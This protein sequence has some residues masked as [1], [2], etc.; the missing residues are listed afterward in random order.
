MATPDGPWTAA[1]HEDLRYN[2]VLNSD[3]AGIMEEFATPAGWLADRCIDCRTSADGACWKFRD[4]IALIAITGLGRASGFP[5]DRQGR[6]E[7]WLTARYAI[8]L[9]SCAHMRF[10]A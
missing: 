10:Q 5:A 8:Y 4:T 2:P 3:R 6:S 9:C 1:A 7:R